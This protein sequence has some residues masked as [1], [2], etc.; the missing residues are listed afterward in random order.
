[1]RARDV[2]RDDQCY[3][4]GDHAYRQSKELTVRV[5]TANTTK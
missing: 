1:M 4:A 2:R 3:N 5:K